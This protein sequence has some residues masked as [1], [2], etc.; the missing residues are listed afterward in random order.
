MGG[1]FC[2]KALHRG[3]NFFQKIYRGM[4]YMGANN[5]SMQGGKLVIQ[6]LQG[7]S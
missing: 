1:L 6:K 7:S 4:L 2:K 5:Q 3:I